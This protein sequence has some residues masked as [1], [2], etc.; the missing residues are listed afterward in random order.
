MK[1]EVKRLEVELRSHDQGMK[2][3]MAERADLVDQVI[4]W[5]AEAITSKDS[6]KEAKLSREKDIANAVD[7]ALAKFKS[8]DEFT[9]LFKKDHDIGFDVEV[10]ASFIIFGRTIGDLD[11]AF[12]GVS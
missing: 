3:L 11:Y 1:K 6:L 7:E 5:E 8:S 9:T 12:L 2:T 4:S 10:E